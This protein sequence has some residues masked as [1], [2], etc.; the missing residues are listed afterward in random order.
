MRRYQQDKT[1][2]VDIESYD[3]L[4]HHTLLTPRHL[5]KTRRAKILKNEDGGTMVVLN[6]WQ[7]CHVAI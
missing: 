3:R 1:Q 6:H 2:Y 5:D 7:V 4:N